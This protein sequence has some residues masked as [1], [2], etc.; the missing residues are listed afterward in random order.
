METI[1]G[2]NVSSGLLYMYGCEP[3]YKRKM[4]PAYKRY[5]RKQKLEKLNNL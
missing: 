3:F 2:R 5:I 1:L 4:T